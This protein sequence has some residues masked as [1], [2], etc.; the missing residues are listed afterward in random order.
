MTMEVA[1][2]HARPRDGRNAFE[3]ALRELLGREV[4]VLKKGTRFNF[5]VADGTKLLNKS[6]KGMQ[7]ADRLDDTFHQD[8]GHS[9]GKPRECLHVS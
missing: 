9:D 1:A 7:R 3:D 6:T 2:E 8:S 4:A 5:D